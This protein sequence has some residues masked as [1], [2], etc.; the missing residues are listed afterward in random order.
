[1]LAKKAQQ[2]VHVIP[3]NKG[4]V[5]KNW[6]IGA[7][8]IIIESINLCLKINGSILALELISFTCIIFNTD[9]KKHKLVINFLHI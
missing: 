8:R 5:I 1:M 9:F 7:C 4:K 6:A 3:W 2:V